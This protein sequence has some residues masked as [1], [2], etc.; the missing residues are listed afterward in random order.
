MIHLTSLNQLLP[1]TVWE[2]SDH[3]SYPGE[4]LRLTIFDSGPSWVRYRFDHWS[5]YNQGDKRDKRFLYSWLNYTFIQ[6]NE[7]VL[8]DLLWE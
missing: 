3:D 6:V 7:E 2:C 5:G 1:G 4:T 8:E